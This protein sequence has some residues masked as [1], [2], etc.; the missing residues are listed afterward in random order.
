[1]P[2]LVLLLLTLLPPGVFDSPRTIDSEARPT[3]VPLG[4]IGTGRLDLLTDGGIG[5]VTIGP[6]DP[7][8]ERVDA[9]GFRIEVR[10]EDGGTV[11]RRLRLRGDGVEDG[12][13]RVRYRG[14]FPRAFVEFTDPALPVVVTLEAWAPFVPHDAASSSFPAVGFDF[15]VRSTDGASHE[16]TLS[17]EWPAGLPLT[18]TP[19]WDGGGDDFAITRADDGRQLD[20]ATT[21]A[22]GTA[23]ALNACLAWHAPGHA[24]SA[25][26]A[27]AAAV[28]RRF[29]GERAALHARTAA[30]H[31][32]LLDPESCSMPPWFGERLAN[33]L[34]PMVTNTRWFA[35]GDYGMTESGTELGRIVGTIDQRMVSHVMVQSWFPALDAAELSIFAEQQ[36]ADGEIPHHFG[37][38]ARFR[39]PDEGFLGWPDL[40]CSFVAQVVKHW[41]WTGDDAFATRMLPHVARAI[42]WLDGRDADGD[43]IA[44]GGSTFDDSARGDGF[45]YTAS[46]QT[47][48]YRAAG[49]LADRLG[50]A[51]LA[52]RAAAG[53][54][55]TRRAALDRLWNGR[56]FVNF[57][58]PDAVEASTDCFVGQVAGDWYADLVDLGPLWP[59][60][61]VDAATDA[62]LSLGDRAGR[63]MPPLET[64]AAG[65]IGRTRYGWLPYTEAYLGA[66]AVQRG[67]ASAGLALVE[68]LDRMLW[69]AARDP[70]NESL[71]YDA[72]TGEKAKPWYTWYMSAPAAWFTLYALL[73]VGVDVPAGS[74]VVA[75][76][77]P[78]E[79]RRLVAPLFLPLVTASVSCRDATLGARRDVEVTI[80]EAHGERPFVLREF[81]T[82]VPWP[83]TGDTIEAH[84]TIDGAP[85]DAE[86]RRDG[87]ALTFVV[88]PPLALEP[89]RR[90]GFRLE[91]PRSAAAADA[92]AA[93]VA[94][95]T[96]VLEDE[97][98]RLEFLVDERGL[99]RT[100]I[101]HRPTGARVHLDTRSLFR[102]RLN[103]PSGPPLFVDLDPMY[104]RT[105]RVESFVAAVEEVGGAPALV[106]RWSLAARAAPSDAA[107]RRLDVAL[108]VSLEPDSNATGWSLAIEG[109]LEPDAR[110][111]LWFPRITARDPGRVGEPSRLVLG[112]APARVHDDPARRRVDDRERLAAGRRA[113]SLIGNEGTLAFTPRFPGKGGA[114]HAEGDGGERLSLTFRLP[115]AAVRAEGGLGTPGVVEIEWE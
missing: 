101:E 73:G 78:H 98:R 35:D 43:G 16:V 115:L 99:R 42:E 26:D 63:W 100:V 82:R 77:L 11:A 46:M 12:V 71:Y 93:A 44:D 48:A 13:E 8:I 66:L 29:L 91:E 72:T 20:A 86:V 70:W 94:A 62:M 68:R 74:L 55:R 109:D 64:S 3:G 59:P 40:A 22:A 17:L 113:F 45:S 79:R 65:R 75:P 56:Y 97:R 28:A 14:I 25:R 76:N 81:A 84:L 9:A 1:M 30:W 60:D 106:A 2:P 102:L 90:I 103:D 10:G 19:R 61:A 69:E 18:A 50:D 53:F 88:S 95:R 110:G 32:R 52:A 57:V 80:D 49:R 111:A 92:H 15:E 21:V 4:G 5:H 108:T 58:D 67:R 33:A 36:A 96:L 23:P 112:D 37:S 34:A 38:L 83:P 87:D 39:A 51:A 114:F 6:T 107:E 24:W 47:A 41:Q 85:R 27:D 54:E 105:V 7:L 104:R 31:D 89:G